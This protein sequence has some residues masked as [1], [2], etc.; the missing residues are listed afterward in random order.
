MDLR[1]FPFG[2]AKQNKWEKD[3]FFSCQHQE[4][5]C[6]GN[7]IMNCAIDNYDMKTQVLPFV[8]C[9]EKSEDSWEVE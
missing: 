7:M 3:F 1:L 8:V 5:E 9:L 2:N 6:E 4:D